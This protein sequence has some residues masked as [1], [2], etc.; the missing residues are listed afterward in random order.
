MLVIAKQS[1]FEKALPT[2]CPRVHLL[3]TQDAVVAAAVPSSTLSEDYASVS[4]LRDDLAARGIQ[5]RCH[6]DINSIDYDG[7]VQLTLQYT[8]VV[9]W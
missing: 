1:P 4:V 8:P 3:L 6:P 9:S 2:P 7:F 5:E